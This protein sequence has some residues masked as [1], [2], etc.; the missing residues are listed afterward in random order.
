M[1][2]TFAEHNRTFQS[3]GVWVPDTANVTG[4]AQPEE[5]HTTC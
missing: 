5:V 2:F 3:L 1:Y 4:I